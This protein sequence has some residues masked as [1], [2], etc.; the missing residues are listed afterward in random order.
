MACLDDAK[1]AALRCFLCCTVEHDV[2]VQYELLHLHLRLSRLPL[3]LLS[4]LLAEQPQVD[5]PHRSLE[6]ELERRAA[7]V[8]NHPSLDRLVADRR[9]HLEHILFVHIEDALT[10]ECHLA[11]VDGGGAD[12]LPFTNSTRVVDCHRHAAG[13]RETSRPVRLLPALVNQP[14][15]HW[16]SRALHLKRNNLSSSR[17][18]LDDKLCGGRDKTEKWIHFHRV[19]LRLAPIRGAS[20]EGSAQRGACTRPK[21]EEQ[22]STV[23]AEAD[24]LANT[25]RS[26]VSANMVHEHLVET[27]MDRGT[28]GW[29][30]GRDAVGLGRM[31]LDT[32]GLRLAWMKAWPGRAWVGSDRVGPV[33]VAA[34]RVRSRRRE[35]EQGGK[36]RD[37]E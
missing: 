27:D 10:L 22:P 36:G 18:L 13:H 35:V 12:L 28:K 6:G 5:P 16:C 9:G 30:L 29:G 7:R 34:I 20:D 17:R 8:D 15:K 1:I 24:Q 31:R 23:S 2:V 14:Q 33:Q 3:V 25:R 37:A 21:A 26:A 11:V 32:F 19:E 4:R